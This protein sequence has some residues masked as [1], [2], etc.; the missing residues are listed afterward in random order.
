V[1]DVNVRATYRPLNNLTVVLRY[2]YQVG[3]LE[4]EADS[5][6]Q[7]ESADMTSHIVSGSVSW[8]PVRRLYLQGR[9]SVVQDTTESPAAGI[10]ASVQDSES[11]FW[12]GQLTAGFAA[13]EAVDL[14]ATYFYYRADNFS[15]NAAA[16]VP[17]GAGSEEN[18]VTASVSWRVTPRI[19]WT[20][21][22]GFISTSEEMYGGH[23][24][25]DAHVLY[26]TIQYRF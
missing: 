14:E 22:Y 13:S 20:G 5:L 18:G 8:V 10:T 7:V 3:T 15:D 16:G 4:N 21:R 26:S 1:D 19:R 23:N 11:D 24:D 6:A 9:L 12:T 25:F 17:Y 2:D